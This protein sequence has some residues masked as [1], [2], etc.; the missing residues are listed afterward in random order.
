MPPETNHDNRIDSGT[1]EN[2]SSISKKIESKPPEYYEWMIRSN[3]KE[4][5][6]SG[7]ILGRL[8]ASIE[9]WKNFLEE[10][11]KKL[12]KSE[13]W[14]LKKLEDT[15]KKFNEHTK[16]AQNK[17]YTETT[18]QETI[19]EMAK[20]IEYVS[21]RIDELWPFILEKRRILDKNLWYGK[22]YTWDGSKIE[23]SLKSAQDRLVFQQDTSIEDIKKKILSSG[24]N[25][26]DFSKASNKDELQKIFWGTKIYIKYNWHELTFLNEN[27]IEKGKNLKINIGKGATLRT[28]I[29]LDKYKWIRETIENR[30]KNSKHKGGEATKSTEQT[31]NKENWVGK[32]EGKL[33]KEEIKKTESTTKNPK[34]IFQARYPINFSIPIGPH[35]TVTSPE[36]YLAS[37]KETKVWNREQLLEKI[38]D[39]EAIKLNSY[40]TKEITKE[41]SNVSKEEALGTI[42]KELYEKYIK[43]FLESPEVKN[44]GIERDKLLRLIN[45][46]DS[47]TNP[48]PDLAKL[49]KVRE[50]DKDIQTMIDENQEKQSDILKEKTEEITLE[51]WKKV[52]EKLGIKISKGE[53]KQWNYKFIDAN[54]PSISYYFKVET[55]EFFISNPEL[56]QQTK[57]LNLW[58]ER[59]RKFLKIP[60]YT[61]LMSQA[62]WHKYLPTERP[63][64]E[65]EL[66][67]T[68]EKNL[69]N[70]IMYTIGDTEVIATKDIIERRQLESTIIAKI[71][72]GLD[73]RKNTVTA[74]N[75]LWYY[76]ILAPILRTFQQP[77]LSI[78][79]L[80]TL[81]VFADRISEKGQSNDGKTRSTE[82]VVS[83]ENF[84]KEITTP[85]KLIKYALSWEQTRELAN[86]QWTSK[87]SKFAIGMFMQWL[88]TSTG[89]GWKENRVID[90]EKLNALLNTR[91][92]PDLANRWKYQSS[93]NEL[94]TTIETSYLKKVEPTVRKQEVAYADKVILP[95]IQNTPA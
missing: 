16:T 79:Q 46:I 48:D 50:N 45:Q 30:N 11:K 36:K 32:I 72:S 92:S 23:D 95:K 43:K 41:I 66:Y 15:I 51:S 35:S 42:P 27:G 91:D 81:K 52:F 7:P 78:D 93:Y 68:I 64:T 38:Q 67:K 49:R 83:Y 86:L 77:N 21:R 29:L 94:L 84:R 1:K 5:K 82:D 26:I 61:E 33:Q 39:K 75:D 69:R 40:G 62:L 47:K 34:K 53:V 73:I 8:N 28:K 2:I 22:L 19:G 74:T 90:T 85:R 58:W 31:Q 76:E 63:D 89:A 25:E 70:R 55:G 71:K 54:N 13:Y 4:T 87:K 60:G 65:K 88:E 44:L 80:K 57:T 9:V 37:K 12:K 24:E 59:F 3:Y 56:S 17:K 6:K 20:A 14:L 18:N 10:F